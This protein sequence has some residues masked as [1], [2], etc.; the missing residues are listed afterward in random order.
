MRTEQEIMLALGTVC[1]YPPSE[2]S[3][4]HDYFTGALAALRW[5]LGDQTTAF[6]AVVDALNRREQSE[7]N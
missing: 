3:D 2:G 5:V 6:G 1:S 7:N 4:G